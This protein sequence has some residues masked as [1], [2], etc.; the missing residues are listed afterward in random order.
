MPQVTDPAL[1]EQLNTGT[2][3]PNPAKNMSQVTDPALL[4][5]LNGTP[6]GPASDA[7][8]ANQ[9]PQQPKLSPLDDLPSG[10]RILA[11]AGVLLN[12]GVNAAAEPIENT[13]EGIAVKAA[14]LLK[15]AGVPVNPEAIDK[16]YQNTEGKEFERELKDFPTT[17][18][19]G[20][21]AGEVAMYALASE[22]FLATK[23][24][25]LVAKTLGPLA[26]RLLSAGAAGASI[27]GGRAKTD[28]GSKAFYGALGA[29]AG[30]GAGE[31]VGG[32]AT[33]LGNSFA[34]KRLLGVVKTL[35]DNF[36]ANA[37]TIGKDFQSV[38]YRRFNNSERMY[39]AVDKAADA[40]LPG[41]DTSTLR[42][43][44]SGLQGGEANR[45]GV[46]TGPLSKTIERLTP[47]PLTNEMPYSRLRRAYL[48]LKRAS[49]QAAKS[50]PTPQSHTL[51]EARDLL[52]TELD[53]AKRSLPARIQRQYNQADTY[54]AEKVGPG[55]SSAVRLIQKMGKGP[56]FT[57][58]KASVQAVKIASGEDAQAAQQLYNGLTQRGRQALQK[59]ILR[60]AFDAA[61]SGGE[62]KP[63]IKFDPEK[64]REAIDSKGAKVFFNSKTDRAML[65][66]VQNLIK[67][68]SSKGVLH[69]VTGHPY[70]VGG[71]ALGALGGAEY[72]RTGDVR[73]S[74]STALVGVAILGGVY[75]MMDSQSGRIM[76]S[77]ASKLN[78]DTP[79]MA[80]FIARMLRASG[81]AAGGMG[82]GALMSGQ[83]QL[84]SLDPTL[85]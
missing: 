36:E 55:R 54:F 76:L 46:S 40:A 59:G 69:A 56:D 8:P 19:I 47:D 26:G 7:I 16:F 48:D 63:G 4:Q 21:A 61:S 20:N 57:P 11:K 34:A 65:D 9:P 79:Q 66:G 64:F 15:K 30:Q 29:M 17:R 71:L 60:Q 18:E 81:A 53:K 12:A 58:Y 1:L 43:K 31:A 42:A 68:S 44:L 78:P 10:V 75:R 80:Q 24:G 6:P 35:S 38:F 2:A 67:A 82:G 84:P 14:A 37:T 73:H 25:G 50:A 85:P 27:E 51:R 23:L 13:V 70:V 22:R 49:A 3:S 62:S 28:T 41:V 39:T 72:E 5:Q 83:M 33:W 77:T 74:I 52:K 45:V 32:V